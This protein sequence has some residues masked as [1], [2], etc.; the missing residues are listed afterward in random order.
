MK[1]FLVVILL[2]ASGTPIKQKYEQPNMEV[3]VEFLQNSSIQTSYHSAWC[4]AHLVMPKKSQ[5]TD[6]SK[7]EPSKK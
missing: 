1:I 2:S 6:S 5:S 4:E 7:N 3:C